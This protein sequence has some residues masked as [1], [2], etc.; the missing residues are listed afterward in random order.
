MEL[1]LSMMDLEILGLEKIANILRQDVIRMAM[2]A[3]RAHLGGPMGLAEVF[4]ALYFKVLK[5]DPKNPLWED[6][7]R[8]ILSNGH[9]CPILYAALARSGYFPVEELTTYRKIN[10]R[11]QG[12][13][14]LGLLLGIEGS[15]GP[16][17]HGISQAVGRAIVA[18]REG[19][20]HRV[21]CVMSDGELDEGQT[22]EAFH[23]A[24]A[25]RLRNLTA[26]L[27]RN[28]VQIDYHTEDR[29][30]LETLLDKIRAF[31]WRAI[32]INGHNVREIVGA[33]RLAANVYEA[34]TAIVCR[35]VFGKGVDFMEND[36]AWHESA[37]DAERGDEALRQLGVVEDEIERKTIALKGKVAM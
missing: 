8:L 32:E 13:P 35:T 22:W 6:R 10:S 7:D 5:H 23:L 37:I 33:C 9:A 29:M 12:H 4:A 30:P 34:P 20:K 31:N 14:H 24:G 16:L 26:L 27:D 36:P 3:G 17:G 25:Q 28:N 18:L 11:L 2:S 21:Y 1:A 15:T 19:R